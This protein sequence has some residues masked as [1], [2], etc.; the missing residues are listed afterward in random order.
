MFLPLLEQARREPPPSFAATGCALGDMGC[1]KL[2]NG[3]VRFAA[4]A[5]TT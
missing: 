4:R 1:A 2:R 3:T 5:M